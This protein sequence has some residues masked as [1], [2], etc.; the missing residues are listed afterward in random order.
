MN[1]QKQILKSTGK[2]IKVFDTSR[3]CWI[4]EH[5]KI[6]L[7]ANGFGQLRSIVEYKDGCFVIHHI[8]GNRTDNRL[9]NL[10]LMTRSEHASLHAKFRD[11]LINEQISC[12]LSG[13]KRSEETKQRMRQAC[14][15]H[16]R[17]GMLG[18]THSEETRHKIRESNIQTWANMEQQIKD[19]LNEN[20]RQKHLG[21]PAHNKGVPCPEHQRKQLSEY[22]KNKYAQGFVSPT[23]GKILVNNGVENKQILPQD[24]NDYLNKG[25]VR[26]MVRR[27]ND[28]Q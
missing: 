5:D 16:P 4:F 26:G 22:W 14:K 7:D 3:G 18:K 12:K 15:L 23:K 1:T 27:K 24:L 13:I 25:Y 11:P 8:N 10:Q 17:A 2:Y 19:T 28:S 9:E 21:K 6:W 20:N